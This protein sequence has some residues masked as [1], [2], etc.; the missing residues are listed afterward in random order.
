LLNEKH[1][2]EI[3][4]RLELFGPDSE[5][6]V[7]PEDWIEYAAGEISDQDMIKLVQKGRD[8]R[9]LK[10]QRKTLVLNLIPNDTLFNLVR[11]RDSEISGFLDGELE[12]SEEVLKA[13]IQEY[14][15][16]D[17]ELNEA[18]KDRNLKRNEMLA[19][20]YLNK[21]K[22]YGLEKVVELT[23]EENFYQEHAPIIDWPELAFLF[24]RRSSRTS[25]KEKGKKPSQNCLKIQERG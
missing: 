18:L 25:R 11:F 19:W 9:A 20:R 15:H 13:K 10:Q 1:Q 4:R 8:L 2:R 24:F 21:Q 5:E 3:Q 17:R 7:S 6:C 16:L 12:L 14:A 22:N 23:A